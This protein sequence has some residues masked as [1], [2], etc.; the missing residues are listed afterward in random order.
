[1]AKKAKK[2]SRKI[3]QILAELAELRREVRAL[4]KAPVEKKRSKAPARK[5][6][7]STRPKPAKESGK[8][9]AAAEK[10][11]AASPPKR[12]MLVAGSDLRR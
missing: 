10:R 6:A 8:P 7:I 3:D 5:T 1:M 11:K 12:P 2:T 4:A 9:S